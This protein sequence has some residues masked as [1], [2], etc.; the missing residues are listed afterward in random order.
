MKTYWQQRRQLQEP[1]HPHHSNVHSVLYQN[2]PLKSSV[3]DEHGKH[4]QQAQSHQCQPKVKQHI[5]SAIINTDQKL[6]KPTL[7]KLA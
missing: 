4:P 5:Q 6:S 3:R 7:V 2:I 1:G